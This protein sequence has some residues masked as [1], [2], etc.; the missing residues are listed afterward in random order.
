MIRPFDIRDVGVLQRL[1]AHARPLATQMIVVGGIHPL[2]EAMRSYVAGGRD[3]VL[4][5]VEREGI[6][7][8][9]IPFAAEAITILANLHDW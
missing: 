3:P 8:P 6:E 2:R 9:N 4:C 1:H 5:L 7:P